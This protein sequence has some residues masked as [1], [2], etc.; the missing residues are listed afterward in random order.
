MERFGARTV[1]ST[2]VDWFSGG[3]ILQPAH[4]DAF[5]IKEIFCS[6]EAGTSVVINISHSSGTLD[7]ESLTCTGDGVSDLDITLNNLIPAGATTTLEI[8]TITNDVDYLEYS[9]WGWRIR[10]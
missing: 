7:T 2:S 3:S 10:E 1:A 6:V 5:R 9:I 4:R 8:G